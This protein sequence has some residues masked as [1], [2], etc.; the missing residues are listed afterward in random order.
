MEWFTEKMAG[1]SNNIP[2]GFAWYAAELVELGV[3]K[4]VAQRFGNAID[5]EDNP[6]SIIK[7]ARLL[8]KQSERHVLDMARHGGGSR[9]T[10]VASNFAED[11]KLK[12]HADI[13]SD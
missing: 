1:Y 5:R 11:V 2:S 7:A 13:V 9:S 8:K 10:S 4:H 12:V 6:L 3:K